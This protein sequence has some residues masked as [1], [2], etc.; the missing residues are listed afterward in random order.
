MVKVK[1]SLDNLSK[2]ITLGDINNEN[3]CYVIDSIYNIN[4]ENKESKI[5]KPA[6]ITLIINSEGGN[7]YDSM[8]LIDVIEKSPTPIHIV[9][10]GQAQSAAFAI[11][12]TGHYRYAGRRA[13]FM[14]HELSWESVQE[15]LTQ[16]KQE[17]Y[18]S[19][20]L[21]KMYQ[22]VILDNTKITRK[23]LD[24]IDKGRKEW[25]INAEEALELGIIDEII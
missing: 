10:Q 13:T 18:E 15:K 24:K 11:V 22:N 7:V 5:S 25:Y 3:I 9:V 23:Q 2:I 16:Y 1:T 14:Y 21:W 8:G 4:Y 17:I 12:T 20:R 6:P 19:N